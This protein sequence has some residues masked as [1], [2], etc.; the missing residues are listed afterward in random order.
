MLQDSG[1]DLRRPQLPDV[2]HCRSEGLTGVCDIIDYQHL[3]AT[4][5]N[6]QREAHRGLRLLAGGG[7]PVLYLDAGQKGEEEEVLDHPCRN[8]PTPANGDDQI[9]M[10]SGML[11]LIGQPSVQLKGLISRL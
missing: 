1:P 4:Y 10:K 5:I 11:D 9:G 3:L 8:V 6:R 7:N 2:V